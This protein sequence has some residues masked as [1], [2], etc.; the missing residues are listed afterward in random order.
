MTLALLVLHYLTLALLVFGYVQSI[1]PG[2]ATKLMA[3]GARLQLLSGLALVVLEEMEGNAPHM[4]IGIKLLVMLGV[5]ALTEISHACGR[6]GEAKPAL[7]HAAAALVVVN[8]IVAYTL[9]H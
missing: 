7:L 2:A 9:P 3:W 4:F 8:L 5:V 6:R 1:E